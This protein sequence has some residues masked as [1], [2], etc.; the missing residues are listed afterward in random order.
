MN[1][2]SIKNKIKRY[3]K[4]YKC[5][6]VA[7]FL[8]STKITHHIDKHRYPRVLQ[9]P[10]T[11]KCNSRCVMCNVTSW[12]LKEEIDIEKF[13]K[14]WNDPLFKHIEAVGING[15]EPFL[16]KN[17]IEIIEIIAQANHVKSI[18]IISNG[19]LTNV[20][21][22][23]LKI[24]YNICKKN[25]VKFFIS[26][27]LDGYGQIH[28]SVRGIPGA[29]KKAISTIREIR[30][31]RDE[32][33]DGYDVGCTVVKQNIDYLTQ[34]DVFCQEENIPI[35][36]RLGIDNARIHNQSI[37]SNYSIFTNTE[38]RQSAAEFFYKLIFKSTTIEDKYKYWA[39][40]DYLIG[41]ENRKLGC[42]WHDNGM[43]LDGEF[44]IYY[45]AV[46]SPK[47]SNLQEESGEKSYFAPSNLKIRDE[48]MC[49]ECEKCIHDYYGQIQFENALKFLYFMYKER[50]WTRRYMND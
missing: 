48:I 11:N 7:K 38:N 19:F 2:I 33:C 28:N 42:D 31:H 9:F 22:D 8:Y 32:Y 46:R 3:D 12:Q 37:Y 29:F 10:I 44:N 6:K 18:N 1:K 45:C 5:L 16:C 15:G 39:I 47:I 4:L 25:D 14:I 40:Y 26:F 21:T 17:L 24:I 13:K 49:H 43:T 27:S 35:K 34:L 20:I 36:Y 23:K 41:H 50:Y 30:D